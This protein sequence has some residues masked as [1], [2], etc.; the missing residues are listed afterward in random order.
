LFSKLA[1]MVNI[2]IHN[3]ALNVQ[4]YKWLFDTMTTSVKYFS[5]FLGEKYHPLTVQI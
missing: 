2:A 3:K 5:K 1:E 4:K